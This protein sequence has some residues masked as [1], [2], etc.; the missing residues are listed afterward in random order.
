MA[1]LSKKARRDLWHFRGQSF[2]IA[3]VMASGIAVLVMAL[4][5]L[6]ALRDSAEAYYT[7]Q[8]FAD[9]FLQLKRA[10]DRLA[11]DIRHL[12]GVQTVQTRIVHTAN[13][14]I[15]GFNEPVTGLLVSLPH[16]QRPT[17]NRPVLRAG[18]W[19]AP[20][21]LDQVVLN[22]PFAQ[23][24]D[25]QPGDHFIAILNGHRQDLTVAGIALSPE[26]IYSLGPGA[27]LPDDQRFGVIWAPRETLEAAYNLKGGF[28]NLTLTL[29]PNTRAPQI[30]EQVDR[31]TLAYGGTGAIGR[32]DQISHWFVLNEIDQLA[33][34]AKILPTIFLG[35]AAFLTH[36]VLSRM[37]TIERSQI[38]LL[39][40]FGYSKLEISWHYATIVLGIVVIALVIGASVGAWLGWL[41][42]NMYTEIFR[43]PVVTY[44]P[45]LEPIIIAAFATSLAALTGAWRSVLGA[46]RLPPAEA[47]QPPSPPKFDHGIRSAIPTG[48]LDQP[49]RIVIRNIV[50]WPGRA[51]L[52]LSGMAASVALLVLTLQ[53]SDSLDYLVQSHFF[54]AQRQHLTLGFAEPQNREVLQNVEDLP[55]VLTAEPM[56]M[57]SA[58]LSSSNR[59]HRGTLLGLTTR[60]LLQPIYDDAIA[61][62][63]ATPKEGLVLGA[64][65]AAKLG[66]EPGDNV[67]VEILE[68]R[69][70]TTELLVVGLVETYMGMPAYIHLEHLNQLTKEAPL[71]GFV[72][73]VVDDAARPALYE[74]LTEIPTVSSVTV[75]EAAI[76]S[77]NETMEENILVFVTIF[78]AL[79]CVMAFGVA[80]N[81]ARITLSER[82]RELATLRVLGFSRGEIS[83]ILLGEVALITVI[84]LPLGCALGWYLSSVMVNAFDTELFRLPLRITPESYA[85]AALY[86]LLVTA[87]SGVV[88]RQRIHNLDL[89]EVLKTRE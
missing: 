71:V 46:A 74:R 9:I 32:A 65:L 76:D 73:L 10:P 57:V 15:A 5:T 34:M 26:Y 2:A 44:Y 66:V 49:S 89:I 83:Y 80:Y 86:T 62:D 21:A 60:P 12:S 14:H 52:T 7:Q 68:G 39:K 50:R 16:N 38:G 18:A 11:E 53:W 42:T 37:L 56:R 20:K 81:S 70:A 61:G 85:Y 47:M 55:A 64:Y 35:V 79:A 67:W 41:L 72:N 82:G 1:T 58:K 23:A 33:T 75:K 4:S 28:N 27:L 54:E 63:V 30:I 25:L 45:R 17:L 24:H 29:A 31:L 22:E 51:M 43:F 19:P 6:A 36:T 40:A 78:G 8:Q 77:L 87:L 84:A 48:W 59:T 88:V 13:L 69:R 3:L